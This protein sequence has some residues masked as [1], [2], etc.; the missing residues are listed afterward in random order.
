MIKTYIKRDIYFERIQPFINKDIIKV[1]IGQ[2]RVG[3]SYFLYQILDYIKKNNKKS[4]II[5]IDKE[6]YKF[7]KIKTYKD[8]YKYIKDNTK[9]GRNYIFID[10]IQEIEKFEKTLRDLVKNKNYDIYITGSNANL[11]SGELSTYLSGRYIEMPIYSLSFIEFLKFHKLKSSKDSLLKYI[12]FGGLPYL[13][14]LKLDDEIVYGYLKSVYNTILLKDIVKRYSIRNISFLNQLVEYLADNVGSLVSANRISNFLKSQKVE[15][16]PNTVLN[17]I[18]FLTSTFFVFKTPRGEISGRKIF[19]INEKYYFGDLGLRHCIINY[20]QPDINK[21]L[22]NLVY[23]HLKYL[24]YE[25]TV[26]IINN[27]EIDF[28]AQ[29]NAKKLYI[30]VTYLITNENVKKI[31]FGNLLNIEDNYPKMV[32][33]MDDFAE[34]EFKGIKHLNILDFLNIRNSKKFS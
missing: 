25:V 34:G 18:S 30:Q 7:Q 31:E 22:E 32:I 15:I 26:G 9:K 19:E 2:R 27:K 3:K 8:L 11:L 20:K 24:G 17:Y 6:E 10:E 14:H 5:Y 12:K 28:V 23:N 1:I 4:N 13:K 29:K 33:S 16:T 21:I